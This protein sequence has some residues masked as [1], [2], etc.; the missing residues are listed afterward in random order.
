MNCA[1]SIADF[2]GPVVER[3]GRPRERFPALSAKAG[4]PKTVD[5]KGRLRHRITACGLHALSLSRRPD[6]SLGI[7]DE[8]LPYSPRVTSSFRRVRASNSSLL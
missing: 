3:E 7:S 8:N 6:D 5:C 4:R 2:A 1:A